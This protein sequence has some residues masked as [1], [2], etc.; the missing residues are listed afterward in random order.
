MWEVVVVHGE[1]HVIPK[2]DR[3]LHTT[4]RMCWCEPTNDDGI[5]V[6]HSQDRREADE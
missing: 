6:H 4:T 2:N 1:R 5:I 3:K